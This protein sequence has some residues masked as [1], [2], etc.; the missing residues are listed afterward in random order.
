MT[1]WELLRGIEASHALE[2]REIGKVT[3]DSR[4]VEPGDIFVCVAGTRV[5]GHDHAAQALQR[6]AAALVVQR[7]LGLP[8]QIRV[9]DSRVAYAK[10]C[11]NFYHNPQD[12]LKLVG[13]TGT[14]GKTTITYLIRDILRSA[15]IKVG[16]I[17][18]IQNEI[19]GMVIPARHTTPD[20]AQLYSLLARMRRAGVEVVV[21]EASSHALDQ[22]RLEGLHFDCA[23]FTN[24]SHEHL[25]YHQTMENYFSAK[26]RLFEM[27]GFAVVNIDDP[28]GVRLT[29]EISC[30][31]WTVS[32]K[33]NSADFTAHS[34]Q[35][36]AKGS[37]FVIIHDAHI[38]RLS[39]GMPGN[40]SVSN[41]L[42]AFACAYRMGVDFETAAKG[43]A[44]SHGV[45]GRM[46]VM[47]LGLPF[48]V[49]RDYAHAPEE[50]K[51]ILDTVRAFAQGRIVTLFGCPGERD[52]QKRSEMGR[53]VAQRSEQVILTSDNPRSEDPMQIIRDTVPGFVG[54]DTPVEIIPDRYDAIAW[55]LRFCREGDILLLLGKGHE[56]YQVLDYGSIC[57]DERDIVRELLGK[58]QAEKGTGRDL[59][60]EG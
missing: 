22:H 34:I 47:E 42:C 45:L 1:L 48:T 25:D 15:G 18:T 56:D 55:A 60:R 53:V 27:S 29:E 23:A 32:L 59:N 35:S 33:N 14:S 16:L 51:N 57:F 26:K 28:H 24:L 20:P 38:A 17:G 49:I 11:A 6:G 4:T 52:R 58:I 3:C 19:D 10:L 43:L 5:D 2:D 54:S 36:S 50:M 13:V 39:L 46:E 30:P 8:G 7:D 40:Y 31:F 21:M 44:G 12:H 37:R 41:A 9:K